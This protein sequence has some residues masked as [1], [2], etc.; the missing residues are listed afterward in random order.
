[1]L[2][3]TSL[4]RWTW[5]DVEARLPSDRSHLLFGMTRWRAATIACCILFGLAAAEARDEQIEITKLYQRGLVGDKQAVTDCITMLEALLKNEPNNQLARVYLGSGY[6]LRSRDLNL[7]PQKLLALKKGI[8]LMDEAVAATPDDAHV[9]L[10]RALTNQSL[11]F[12]LG[13]RAAARQDFEELVAIV[14]KNPEKLAP[15]DRQL[16]FLNA[17]IVAKQ[18]G[19]KVR[20]SDLWKRGLRTPVDPKLTQ[21]LNAALVGN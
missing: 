4:V 21:E 12:F 17:G 19:D 2:Y 3:W 6:T 16:L 14:S 8:A 15:G 11:P 10:V 20:A 7:G 18:G 13:R 9:R 5:F 1:M